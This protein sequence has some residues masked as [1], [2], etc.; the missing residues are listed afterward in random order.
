M[1]VAK[2]SKLTGLTGG[3]LAATAVYRAD[4]SGVGGSILSI[5]INDNSAGLGGSPGQFS[6]F[7]L[8]AIILS[9]TNCATA[10]CPSGWPECPYSISSPGLCSA[11]ALNGRR[12]I[13]SCSELARPGIP[14]TTQLRRS[15]VRWRV[16]HGNPRRIRLREHWR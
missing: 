1:S 9:T 5:T 13:P 14:S 12:S 2:T 7:D 16:D 3:T 4:L 10:A 11:P 8:D 15:A 6:G